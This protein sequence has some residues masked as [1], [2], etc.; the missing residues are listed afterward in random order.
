MQSLM[1]A[2]E[3]VLPLFLMLVVG[4]IIKL[5]KLMNETTVKQVNKS[6]FRIFLPLLVFKN[7]YNTDI[8]QSFNSRLL[9]Y[10]VIGVLLQFLI[11][12]C[13]VILVEKENS[14]RGVML[15]GMFRSN[16]VLFGIP[17]ATAL[18]GSTAAGVASVLIAVIVP[19]YNV[20]AVLALEMFNGNRPNL[21]KVFAGI[22]TN[23][24]IL[25]SAAAFAMHFL[26]FALPNVLYTTL[27]D[28]AAIATPLAFVVL[29]A[30]FSFGDISRYAKQLSVT[31]FTKLLFFPALLLTLS[32]LFGFRNADLA[33]LLT[34]FASPIAVSSFTMAQ[35]MGG[36]EKL[37]GQLVVFSSVFSIAT[38]FLIIFVLKEL[39][40]YN[41]LDNI[42]K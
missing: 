29:G 27:N 40:F 26:H 39:A 21:F 25:A 32:I 37:A 38:I 13:V 33:V 7:I 17:I 28:L 3:V 19:M 15:Q 42:S 20:L 35:E 1:I 22:I 2:L 9:L 31:L 34:V 30:S 12:L 36:D 14:R 11:A 24:L 8:S 4:Y 6:I 10:T 18:F 41:T 23:P 16:F 5:S